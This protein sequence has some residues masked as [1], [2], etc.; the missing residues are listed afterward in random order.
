MEKTGNTFFGVRNRLSQVQ[1]WLS[2]GSMFFCAAGNFSRSIGLVVVCCNCCGLALG[3]AA[4]R[5]NVAEYPLLF[6]SCCFFSP[7]VLPP[8]KIAAEALLY[9]GDVRKSVASWFRLTVVVVAVV[10]VVVLVVA[11]AVVVVVAVARGV[12]LRPGS[13]LSKGWN[14]ILSKPEGIVLGTPFHVGVENNVGENF[15]I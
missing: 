9:T 10:V 5:E 2:I 6:F 15:G 1:Y 8:S 13:G 12:G 4:G 3:A 11:V 14:I 7:G